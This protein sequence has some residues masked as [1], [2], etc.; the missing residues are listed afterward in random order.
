MKLKPSG[1]LDTLPGRRQVRAFDGE[2][3]DAAGVPMVQQFLRRCEP[4]AAEQADQCA[5]FLRGL[6]G[7]VDPFWHFA[8]TPQEVHHLGHR[9][10]A[11]VAS[12]SQGIVWKYR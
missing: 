10:R 6:D 2:W 9:P 8:V 4:A 11:E 7:N 3:R 12:L 5:A 1:G